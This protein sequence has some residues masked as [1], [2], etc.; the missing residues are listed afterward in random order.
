[1]PT[2]EQSWKPEAEQLGYPD[3]VSMLKGLYT[4][5]HLSINQ[6]ARILGYSSPV[7]RVRIHRA[8]IEV[9]VKGGANN[10]GKRVL[11]ALTDMELFHTPIAKLTEAYN[12]HETTV[13]NERRFRRKLKQQ[14]MKVQTQEPTLP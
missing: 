9:R 14:E 10:T 6:I 11:A 13:S 5:Q 7:V 12:V 8:G 3:E 4:D 1:M 2:E